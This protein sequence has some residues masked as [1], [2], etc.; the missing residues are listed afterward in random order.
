MSVARSSLRPRAFA[1]VSAMLLATGAWACRGLI[2]I[3]DRPLLGDAGVDAA[4][5][6]APLSSFCAGLTPPAQFCS[7]FDDGALTGWANEGKTPNPGESGGGKMTLDGLA[8]SDPFGL[9]VDTPALVGSS[10][11]AAST[12][13][14]Y[15]PNAPRISATFQMYVESEEF[16]VGQGGFVILATVSFD[17]AGGL[18]FY[19]T[20]SGTWF[21]VVPSGERKKLSIPVGVGAW[22]GV[23]MVLRNASVDGGPDGEAYLVIDGSVAA[24]VPLPAAFQSPRISPRLSLGASGTGPAGAFRASFDDV[25]VYYGD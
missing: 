6:A 7:D 5:E 11:N 24:T 23:K 9:R 21:G 16:P 19:R 8:H 1:T 20:G 18:I 25:A 12:V 10:S 2:G 3:E 13:Q 4:V 17:D 22:K 14:K 15:L